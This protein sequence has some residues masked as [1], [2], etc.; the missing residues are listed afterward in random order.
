MALHFPPSNTRIIK[1]TDHSG[2]N[3]SKTSEKEATVINV[4]LKMEIFSV[5]WLWN[6]APFKNSQHVEEY[7]A[8]DTT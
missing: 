6:L 3:T 1:R 2:E 5:C 4:A 7:N 8:S